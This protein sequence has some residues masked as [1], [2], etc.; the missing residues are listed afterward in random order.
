MIGSPA[1]GSPDDLHICRID[2]SYVLDVKKGEELK[3]ELLRGDQGRHSRDVW[4][5]TH[6]YRFIITVCTAP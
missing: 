4:H 5:V 3:I 6:T 2:L 1:E